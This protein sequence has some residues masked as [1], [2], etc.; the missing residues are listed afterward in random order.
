MKKNNFFK[1]TFKLKKISFFKTIGHL[2]WS[3]ALVIV[4]WLTI[5]HFAKSNYH[6]NFQELEK[7]LDLWGIFYSVYGVLYA[8][9]AGFVLID[10]FTRYNHIASYMQEEINDLQDIRDFIRLLSDKN[11][12]D[13]KKITEYIAKYVK[14]V[15]SKELIERKK[16]EKIEGDTA[17]EIYHILRLMQNLK[18]KSEGDKIIG[19]LLFEKVAS[20]TTLRTKRIDLSA[21]HLPLQLKLLLNFMS[22]VLISGFVFLPTVNIFI[23]LLI[24]VSLSI[25]VHFLHLV[26]YDMD[27]PFKGKWNLGQKMW[28]EFL[29]SLETKN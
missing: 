1:I 17:E 24:I 3:T 20:V 4:V 16:R 28:N 21:Q 29:E 13:V 14:E 26:L 22:I 15:I 8:I 5:N 23:S 19:N 9:L 11:N 27:T 2:A 6:V 12:G 18:M 10:V 7:A 25:S